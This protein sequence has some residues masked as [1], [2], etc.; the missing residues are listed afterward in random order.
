M[1]E[2]MDL[3]DQHKDEIRTPP[4]PLNKKALLIALAKNE[5]S[6]GKDCTPRLEPAYDF[7]GHY[8]RRS[9]IIRMQHRKFGNAVAKSYGPFQVMYPTAVE[10]GYDINRPPEELGEFETNIEYAIRYINHRALRKAISVQDIFDAY[11][12]GSSHDSII[13]EGYILKGMA[14]YQDACEEYPGG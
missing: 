5:S 14:R 10:L 8:F 12:S 1:Q 13:P 7:G 6:F 3:I 9:P 4:F 2:L 11:N